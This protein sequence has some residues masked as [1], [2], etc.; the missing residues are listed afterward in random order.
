MVVSPFDFFRTAE[1]PVP[2]VNDE[3]ARAIAAEC[4]G[5]HAAVTSLGSQQDANFLLRE[6]VPGSNGGRSSDCGTPIGVLK[7]ANPAFSLAEL[8]AQDAAAAFITA[9]ED[10]RTATNMEFAGRD[11]IAAVDVDGGVLARVIRYLDGGTLSGEVYLSPA[12]VG[13]L[14]DLAGR[15]TRAL[16][17][18]DHVGVERVLQWDLRHSM[19]TVELLADHAE[20][21][22]LREA[23][24]AA[25]G[26]AWAIIDELAEDLPVQVIHGD[27]TG[28]NVVCD[29]HGIPNGLIDFGDLTRSW[30][31]GEL[32]VAV[33]SV[34]GHDGAEPASTLVAIEAFHAIRPLG[35]AEIEALWPLVVLRAAVL[36]VSGMQQSAID[37]D[38]IYANTRQD[39]ELLVFERATELPLDVMTNQIRHALG[40][41]ET[42]ESITGAAP[43]VLGLNPRDVT[44][45]DLSA[46]SDA[47]DGGAWLSADCEDRV[48]RAAIGA[49]A[50][51]VVTTFAHAQLT[52]STTLSE[53]S[54]ATVATGVRLWPA[55]EATLTAPWPGTVEVT[56]TGDSTTLTL[57]AQVGIVRVRGCVRPESALGATRDVAAGTGLGMIE[58]PVWIQCLRHPGDVAVP[59]FVC[60]EYAAGWLDRVSD[61]A[62]LLGLPATSPLAE[63]SA[64][65]RR[66]RSQAFAE[67]QEHYYQNPPRI[68]RGWREHLVGTDGRVYLDMVNNVA[69]IGHGHPALADAAARQWRRLNTNSRFNYASVATFSERLAA[70]LP[71]PLDTVFLVN[72]GSESDDLALRLAMATTGRQDVVAVAEAYH[73]WTY[74]TDAI[75]TSIADNPNALSTRPSWVHTVPSPNAFRGE[76]RG[77]EAM[78]YAP[79]AVSIIETLAAQGHPPAAFIAEA[80]Y[81]NAGGMAL[82]DGYLRAVYA[83]VRAVGGLA[84][85]DEVQVGYGRT[86]R[87]FWA[88]EQQDVIPD[89][90]CV[91]KAMGNG[92]PLG[93]VITTRAI[94][95]AYRTQGYFFSSAGG[96][97]VSCVIGM[98]VLDVIERERLQENALTVGDHLKARILDLASRHALIGTVH[99]SGLYMGVE[100]VRDRTTLEPA[101]AETAAICERMLQLGVIVQPTG[102][103][104]NVLKMKPPMCLTRDSAD[105]FVDMLDRVLSTGW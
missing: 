59:D 12:A 44:R 55:T 30:T 6:D 41:A 49:G 54:S 22:D 72:S 27:V 4:F 77:V 53:T 11:P 83:A 45:L 96:S 94:A 21:A 43:L 42:P 98:T 32:A 51:A 68:E 87:W 35:P 102:D 74:A 40:V 57:T 97:P 26:R 89:I 56:T 63:D 92:Q 71:D 79:E 100:L 93:A 14:G 105:F 25:T 13:A 9:A 60:P 48:A 10:I 103:R 61:P 86:G 50:T 7:I 1:L 62:P 36:V 29:P 95:E 80:F 20:D 99:G 64:T 2:A 31:I 8:Q 58:G 90:V 37:T 78:K 104:L 18:F 47:M 76:H 38:N 19:R 16:A 75:S 84:I 24:E 17:N 23:L 5:V 66:R 33:A 81:G 67:V 34:L 70:T 91:A 15:T 82:P 88:F 52:R 65:L 46:E 85:A 101:A 3:Q 39:L 73:G 28:D 69:V